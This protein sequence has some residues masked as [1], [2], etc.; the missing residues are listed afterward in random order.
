MYLHPSSFLAHQYIFFV[1]WYILVTPKWMVYLEWCVS[2]KSFCLYSPLFKTESQ[3]SNLMILSSP[4]LT[5][6]REVINPWNS[7]S[8]TW[9]TL[10]LWTMSM[11]IVNFFMSE[12]SLHIGSTSVMSSILFYWLAIMLD[13]CPHGFRLSASTTT[14]AF[15][16]W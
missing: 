13:S 5:C 12:F 16:V 14:L 2:C 4:F 7:S 10:I 15:S 6:S 3:P 11:E 1:S 8:L 9:A